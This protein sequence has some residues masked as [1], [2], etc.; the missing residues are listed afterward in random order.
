M[1]TPEPETEKRRTPSKRPRNGT[2]PAGSVAR[3]TRSKVEHDVG[4][5]KRDKSES[6]VIEL[7]DSSVRDISFSLT[8]PAVENMRPLLVSTTGVVLFLSLDFEARTY[9]RKI[10]AYR[11]KVVRPDDESS[12]GEVNS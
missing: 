8:I 1:E 2:P 3:R 5:I 11:T 10:T 7:H 9:R 12:S 6:L 4:S